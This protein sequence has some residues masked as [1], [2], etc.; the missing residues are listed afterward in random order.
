M[1]FKFNDFE[2]ALMSKA[3]VWSF[4]HLCFDSFK[5]NGKQQAVMHQRESRCVETK[6]HACFG[7]KA[8][9]TMSV[10]PE[11]GISEILHMNFKSNLLK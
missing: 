1:D 9:V 3:L 11:N 7:R 4:M 2:K 5:S 10:S 6:L 8:P